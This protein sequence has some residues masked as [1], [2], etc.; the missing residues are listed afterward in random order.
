[1]WHITLVVLL[2]SCQDEVV[3]D[4]DCL[5][6]PDNAFVMYPGSTTYPSEGQ[7]VFWV[8]NAGAFVHSPSFN[9]NNSDEFIYHAGNGVHKHN[10]ATKEDVIIYGGP[11]WSKAYWGK[12]DLLVFCSEYKIYTIR[13]D[14]TGLT[15]RSASGYHADAYWDYS[16]TKIIYWNGV[17]DFHSYIMDTVGNLLYSLP[18]GILLYYLDWLSPNKVMYANG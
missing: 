14:G 13:P 1:M 7:T 5:I 17:N 4:G 18:D 12:G 10:L 16:G 11:M 2:L 6:L 3:T 8:E 15:L 9:P